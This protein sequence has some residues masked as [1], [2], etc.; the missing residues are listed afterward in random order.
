ML[1]GASAP[2]SV[3]AGD[4][5]RVSWTSTNAD[6]CTVAPLAQTGLAGDVVIAAPAVTTTYALDCTGRGGS[7][8]AALVLTI[9]AAPA[10]TAI[11]EANGQ[12]GHVVVA[13]GG[14]VDLAWRSQ[15]ATACTVNPGGLSGASGAQRVGPMTATTRWEATCTGPGG[16]ARDA[17]DVEVT[18]APGNVGADLKINGQDGPVLAPPGARVTVSWTSRRARSCTVSPGNRT[19][20]S[21]SFTTTPLADGETYVLVCRGDGGQA[22]DEAVVDLAAQ[23]VGV[24]FEDRPILIGDHDYNDFALCFKGVFGV[25]KSR[26]RSYADQMVTVDTSK[27]SWCNHK[28]WIDV[29]HDDGTFE[30]TLFFESRD[31]PASF[32]LRFRPGSRLEAYLRPKGVCWLGWTF[33]MH[34]LHAEVRPNVCRTE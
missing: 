3:G 1:N 28:V 14:Y 27:L 6:R 2:L 26:V 17:V 21:G 5:V 11:L 25:Q 15:D 8:H 23:R 24:N 7:A 30:P 31:S 12:R 22:R 32:D 4:P 13:Y 18:P 29:V 19:G 16:A 9:V 10:P 33:D 34:G 20:T